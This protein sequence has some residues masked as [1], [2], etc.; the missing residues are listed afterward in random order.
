MRTI[1]SF[2]LIALAVACQSDPHAANVEL[3]KQYVAAVENLDYTAM[4]NL[5]ADNYEGYGP[6]VGDTLQKAAAVAGWKKNVADLYEKISYTRS[7]FAGVTIEEGPNQGNWV[8]NWAELKI[9][10][11][12]GESVTI[13]ANTNYKIENGKIARTITLYN[14][15]DVLEQ[16]GYIFIDP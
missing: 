9:E 15:A 5:L 12:D 16:L 2:L 1:I 3:V 13:W 10:Y 4:E 8:A 6:S 11:K 14:E 7:Q